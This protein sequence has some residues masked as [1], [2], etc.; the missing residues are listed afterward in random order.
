M[1][2]YAGCPLCMREVK[3]APRRRDEGAGKIYFVDIDAPE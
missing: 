1:A 3:H 2:W